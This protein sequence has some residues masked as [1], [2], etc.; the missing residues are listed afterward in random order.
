[1]AVSDR[2]VQELES[3]V[4]GIN[5]CAFLERWGGSAMLGAVLSK[6]PLDEMC[7]CIED[8]L[9]SQ[10]IRAFFDGVEPDFPDPRM[11]F[12]LPLARLIPFVCSCGEDG[13]IVVD[14]DS[15]L[16][17]LNDLQNAVDGGR[18]DYAVSM[19]LTNIDIA[20][21]FVL[22]DGTTFHKLPS[23]EVIHKYTF[24]TSAL[25]NPD[26]RVEGL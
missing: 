4:A 12:S 10:K 22:G 5:A 6:F 19:H 17:V 3:R 21:D 11:H 8:E 23:S 24:P 9:G 16:G 25:S 1:M 13:A 26:F 18:V 14:S 2:F 7:Q 15:L 20:D